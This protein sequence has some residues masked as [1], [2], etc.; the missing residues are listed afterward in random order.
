MMIRWIPTYNARG[1]ATLRAVRGAVIEAPDK[2]R[3]M[4]IAGAIY[5]TRLLGVQSVPSAELAE[6]E[7]R[8]A[9]QRRRREE[10]GA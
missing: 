2:I 9:K 3:A 6:E 5:D 4:E 1:D 8:A 7:L 10:D